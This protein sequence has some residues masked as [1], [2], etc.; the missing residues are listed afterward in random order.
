MTS[1]TT[2]GPDTAKA[3]FEVWHRKTGTRFAYKPRRLVGEIRDA[4]LERFEIDRDQDRFGLFDVDDHEL[5]LELTLGAAGV[6]PNDELTLRTRSL[7]V[8][9]NGR[10]EEFRYKPRETVGELLAQALLRFGVT[11]N[12]HLM[13]L[14][15]DQNTE[16]NE[17]FTLRE[18]NVEP[19]STLV[20]RQSVVKGG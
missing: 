9:Y 3:T 13:S 7:V 4:A 14:F 2:A 19:G 15:D 11:T 8:I 12:T 5:N 1:P 18:A 20:L 16:L 17:Q 10:E 6:K